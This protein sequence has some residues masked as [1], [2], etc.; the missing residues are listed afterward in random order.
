MTEETRAGLR[1]GFEALVRAAGAGWRVEWTATLSEGEYLSPPETITGFSV[2]ANRDRPGPWSTKHLTT[3]QQLALSVLLEDDAV[4]P[5]ALA[6]YLQDLGRQPAEVITFPTPVH[7]E[8]TAEEWGR[9]CR[10]LGE[11]RGFR[12]TITEVRGLMKRTHGRTLGKLDHLVRLVCDRWCGLW[13][14]EGPRESRR[15]LVPTDDFF[16]R[17]V[18]RM[19][20]ARR[21]LRHI[22]AERAGRLPPV[23]ARVLDRCLAALADPVDASPAG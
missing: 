2:T 3:A 13:A 23:C 18:E 1:H 14:A 19:P 22:R 21:V 11:R 7:Q 5:Q 15:Y 12:R 4:L 10:H 9:R 8:V 17:Q 16:D 20:D 6:D